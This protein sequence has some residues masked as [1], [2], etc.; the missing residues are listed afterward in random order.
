MA[1]VMLTPNGESVAAVEEAPA[2]GKLYG[3]KDTKWEEVPDNYA[4]EAPKDG[5]YYAR[6]NGEWRVLP[7][8]TQAERLDYND[9]DAVKYAESPSK[10][11]PFLTLKQLPYLEKRVGDFKLEEWPDGLSALYSVTFGNNIF[12]AVGDNCAAISSDGR[13]W[14]VSATPSGYWRS[15]A[16]GGGVF[17]AVGL[18]G[19]AMYSQ[20]NGLTWEE[21]TAPAGD[22]AA[23]A[24]GNGCFISVCDG[25]VMKSINGK[26]GWSAKDVPAGYGEAVAFGNGVFIAIGFKGVMTSTDG[27]NW[28]EQTA[29]KATWRCGDYGDGKFIILAGKCAYSEDLGSSWEIKE[30]PSGGWDAV[31]F[32][33]GFFVGVGNSSQC[34]IANSE[35]L[36]FEQKSVPN[37][38]WR[39]LA[40]GLDMFVAVG[41][42]I[43]TAN[44]VDAASAIN[45][46]NNPNG[47]NHFATVLDLNQIL[48]RISR[49]ENELIDMTGDLSTEISEIKSSLTMKE[50]A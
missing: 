26:T 41:S 3:R 34:I 24:Y 43:M 7:D 31:Q 14:T 49:L 28:T 39:D 37:F 45:N 30:L 12:A 1:M 35:Y 18:N 25:Q 16:Y 17:S 48:D 2:D 36:E 15:V 50:G 11:N 23:A 29:P 8:T 27:E 33:D 21:S 46:A 10:T 4:P 47:T 22:W 40:F 5:S 9:V 6:G 20:D 13:N 42:G 44:I 32:G 38:I 19:H